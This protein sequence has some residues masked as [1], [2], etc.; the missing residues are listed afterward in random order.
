[1]SKIVAH[2]HHKILDLNILHFQCSNT[3]SPAHYHKDSSPNLSYFRSYPHVGTRV[4]LQRWKVSV[5]RL[6]CPSGGLGT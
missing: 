4:A 6:L 1:M 5:I 2:L 3:G